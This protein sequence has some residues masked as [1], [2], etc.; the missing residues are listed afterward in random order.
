VTDDPKKLTIQYIPLSWLLAHRHHD[1][2]K[3]HDIPGIRQSIL[4]HGYLDAGVLDQRTELVLSCHGRLETLHQMKSEGCAVPRFIQGVG[5]DWLVPIQVGWSSDT[6]EEAAAA[7]LRINRL[8]ERGGWSGPALS[9]FD[10]TPDKEL[11]ASLWSP[12]ELAA[13]LGSA[14]PPEE[15]P[16]RRQSQGLHRTVLELHDDDHDEL[17]TLVDRGRKAT[18]LKPIGQVVLEA[19]RRAYSAEGLTE[20]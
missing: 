9:S 1:N 15:G 16:A 4:E 13:V 8:P 17:T 3:N 14:P 5:D 6:D 10:P 7:L 18:G 12:D 20:V 2:P 19:L 11:L